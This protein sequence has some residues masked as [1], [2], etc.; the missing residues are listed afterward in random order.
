MANV[1]FYNQELSGNQFPDSPA[2]KTFFERHLRQ[3]EM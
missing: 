3:A 1:R 2:L